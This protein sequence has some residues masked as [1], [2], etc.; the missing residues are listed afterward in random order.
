MKSAA[1]LALLLGLTSPSAVSQ[2]LRAGM[3]RIAKF[4]RNAPSLITRD[5]LIPHWAED[6][7][8]LIYRINTAPGQHQF[9]QIDLKS[10]KKSPAFDHSAL[11]KALAKATS[12]K[13]SEDALPLD[14]IAPDSAAGSLRFRAFG[15]AWSH[16][17]ATRTLTPTEFP[18]ASAPLIDPESALR[19]RRENGEATELII[20]NASPGEIEI[21]WLSDAG[22]RKSYGRIASGTTRRQ[23]TYTGHVWLVSD[24]SGTPLAGVKASSPPATARITER[25]TPPPQ[26][27]QNVSPDGKWRAV[28]LQNNVLLEPTGSGASISLSSDGSEDHPYCHPLH[29]SPDSKSLIA[30]RAKKVVSRKIHI[31]QSSPPDQLQPKLKSIDYPKPGDEIRQPKPY[32]FDVENRR[33][34][35]VDETLFDNP[36]SISEA[37]WT[38]DSTEFSFAYNQRGHQ[39]MRV[40]GIQRESGS[41]R[42][43]LEDTSKTFIDYSQKF[44]LHRIPATREILWASER[45]GY[46][47]L[48][49]IDEVS[50]AVKNPITRGKWNVREVIEVDEAK[51]QVLLKIVGVSGQDPYHAHFARVNFDGSG[52]TRLTESD[53]HHRIEFSPDRNFILATGSRVDQA[54]VT[55]LRRAQDGTLVAVLERADDSALLRTGWT[56]PERFV[57]KA[58]DGKTDIHGIIVRPT[59]FDP[60]KKY[61]IVEDIYAGPHDHFVPKSFSPWFGLNERAE[62]GFIVV[63]IDGM[64]TNWRGKAFHDVSWKNLMD[65]GFPDRIA[66]IKAAA[67]KRRWMDLSR[68]GIYGGSAGGQSTLAGL[69]HH[70]NFYQVGVADCGCHDNR[71][72]KVW[73]NEAWMGWPVDESYARNS[74]VTHVA[75]LSGKLMLIVGELDTNVD[76]ASTAQVVNALTLAD[77]DFEFVPIMN[78]GHGAAETPFGKRRRAEFLVR[79]LIGNSPR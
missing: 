23:T 63:K 11:A 56:R 17:P 36:W 55:E 7:S 24:A 13:V 44:Y 26:R 16:D 66:W 77:K 37:A 48:Y 33:A 46:N 53:G 14:A 50:G 67:A 49:L 2:N 31:V 73:W 78:A 64:G 21:F 5:Q 47:H 41:T 51:R 61:P 43:I 25:V 69:L 18:T 58:R 74:N 19:T 40:V 38:P 27:P 52:M 59:H 62:L 3:E 32:L 30:F 71:M 22:E 28:I 4:G 29:W 9:F 57:A 10:G 72:D 79:H 1:L 15:Q 75:K 68:V 60:K 70:G 35:A 39:V 65:S 20:E 45:D 54:P 6:G 12:R 34:V 42:T 76:P 8:T